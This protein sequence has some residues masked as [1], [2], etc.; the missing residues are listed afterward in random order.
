MRE[1]R[2]SFHFDGVAVAVVVV[3]VS[4]VVPQVYY[5]Y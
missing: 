5:P 3:V 1:L 4:F 2:E